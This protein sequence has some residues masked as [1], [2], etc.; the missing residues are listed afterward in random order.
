[1]DYKLKL[2]MNSQT[3]SD[4]YEQKYLKYKIKYLNLK[5][6]LGRGGKEEFNLILTPQ[7]I[8]SAL[9]SDQ[10]D[11]MNKLKN[12]GFD[13]TYSYY[14]TIKLKPEQIEN[15]IKLKKDDDIDGSYAYYSVQLT[16]DQNNIMNIL[17]KEGFNGHYS[18]VGARDLKPHQIETM[19]KLR[20]VEKIS[21]EYSFKGA[22][23]EPTKINNMIMLLEKINNKNNN[24]KNKSKSKSKITNS[25]EYYSY[26]GATELT[27]EQIDNMVELI[28]QHKFNSKYAFKGATLKPERYKKMIELYNQYGSDKN[29]YMAVLTMFNEKDKNK[30]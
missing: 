6:Q 29:A 11:T 28:N 21:D 7:V 24:N 13:E 10:I 9:N 5:Q 2:F 30:K 23:L 19:I 3:L 1:M 27:S 15:M 16:P 8:S 25:D 18:F 17:K 14:G 22:E 26:K 4:S 12:A 20:N